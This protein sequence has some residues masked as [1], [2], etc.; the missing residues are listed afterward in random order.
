MWAFWRL[1]LHWSGSVTDHHKFLLLNQ[2]YVLGNGLSCFLYFLLLTQTYV[3]SNVR[4]ELFIVIVVF[5][6]VSVLFLFFTTDIHAF[7]YFTLFLGDFSSRWFVSRC[8]P[9]IT[10]HLQNGSAFA[11]LHL[12]NTILGLWIFNTCSKY[13]VT[14]VN[15]LDSAV[16]QTVC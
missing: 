12:L 4:P 9:A 14:D 6:S 1:V 16:E 3:L 15:G 11:F 5:V 10:S 8:T 2:T 13:F 7:I